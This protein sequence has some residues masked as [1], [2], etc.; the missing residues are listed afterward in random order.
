MTHPAFWMV[1]L[2]VLMPSMI[3][4]ETPGLLPVK[5]A[6]VK[7]LATTTWAAVA[8]LTSTEVRLEAGSLQSIE[9]DATD[10]W[11]HPLLGKVVR[12]AAKPELSSGAYYVQT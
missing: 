10:V 7:P 1:A 4:L 2:G 8:D 3:R 12:F 5:E 11:R 6:G 9:K